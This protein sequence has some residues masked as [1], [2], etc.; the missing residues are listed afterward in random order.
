MPRFSFI[1]K[2]KNGRSIENFIDASDR[3][4]AS[5]LLQRQG[6]FVIS[7]TE[8]SMQAQQKRGGPVHRVTIKH[9][10]KKIKLQD[11]IVFARQLATM[12][13]AGVSLMRSLEVI[14]GQVESE[15][16]SNI[17]AKVK[18]DV[19]KGLSLSQALSKHPR[20]FNQF[21]V[22]LV[23]VGEASGTLP[24]VLNKLTFYLDQQN[25]FRS[26]VISSVIYP[27]LLFFVA[28]GA[29]A[30]FALFVGPR[31]EGIFNQM[32]IKLPLI[33][34]ILLATFAFVRNY[35]F[36]I[37]GA[38]VISIFL[39]LQSIK[40]H[41]GKEM[42]ERFLFKVPSIGQIFRLIVVERFA[43]QMAILIEAGVP[44]L[45]ALDIAE[46]LV[47]NITCGK[48]VRNIKEGVKKGELLVTPMEKSGF[49][50]A[51]CVQLISVGE[52][53]GELSKMLKHV[54]KY[55][56]ELVETYIKRVSTLIEP[57]MIVFMGAV[58]GT[59]VIAM[60]LPLFKMSTGGI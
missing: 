21:W 36:Y 9:K 1:A 51:M 16:L 41:K 50:P 58:I 55:Y 29:I 19:E 6:Y 45:A 56:Q 14:S 26:T 25:A 18:N 32:S 59:I 3:I 33:T 44:I 30:F 24:M 23:E 43:G 42:F 40:T 46:K 15:R 13:E 27:A 57:A 39:F 48:I 38:I 5:D 47:D 7:I 54:S 22:S 37:V 31:F 2:D 8:F 34:V 4:A 35:F 20:A 49:F 12:L 11:V 52:E 28:C 17:V 60:F 10:H 53:T